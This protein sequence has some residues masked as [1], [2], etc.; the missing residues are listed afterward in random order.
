MPKQ[1]TAAFPLL[2][3]EKDLSVQ[4]PAACSHGFAAMDAED[5]ELHRLLRSDWQHFHHV[6]Q[7][8]PRGLNSMN[9]DGKAGCG[10]EHS[11]RKH[12]EIM[13]NALGDE[14]GQSTILMAL[15]TGTI[16]IGFVGLA[17][18]VG[19]LYREKSM[20]QTAADAGAIAAAN[21]TVGCTCGAP[22]G[23]PVA[24]TAPRL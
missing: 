6:E 10:V 14:R 15:L 22:T 17:V 5:C 1:I 20:A 16:L 19:M 7:M 23:A 2:S 12:L 13:K 9:E 4:V 3:R 11:G 8:P 24:G 18:D 21:V